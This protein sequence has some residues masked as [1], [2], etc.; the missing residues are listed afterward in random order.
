MDSIFGD[1]EVID[2]D[3]KFTPD[4]TFFLTGGEVHCGAFFTEIC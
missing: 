1:R 4:A 3:I 2:F